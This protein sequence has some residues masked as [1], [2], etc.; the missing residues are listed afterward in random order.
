MRFRS[1]T[2]AL[3][4]L[5]TPVAFAGAADFEIVKV[6]SVAGAG[7]DKL[8]PKIIFFNDYRLDEM[9]DK[10]AFIHFDEWARTKPIQRQ[11]LSLF[12][13][14]TEGMIHRVIDGTRKEVKD[15]LQ[16]FITE[17]RFLLSKPA[18]KEFPS[19]AKI[20][21]TSELSP[22]WRTCTTPK[23]K[24]GTISRRTE[25]MPPATLKSSSTNVPTKRSALTC[26]PALMPEEV[27]ETTLQKGFKIVISKMQ[28]TWISPERKIN[29]RGLLPLRLVKRAFA[30]FRR[31]NS[32]SG[33]ANLCDH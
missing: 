1:A 7:I 21:F 32:C 4:M 26:C 30:A 25:R 14:F 2:M 23:L 9:S 31:I 11:F 10:G 16:M 19:C 6:T 20:A 22:V 15:E 29:W 12:P 24:S 3:L 13:S 18:A 8:K 33:R 28:P 27:S 17:A 5:A